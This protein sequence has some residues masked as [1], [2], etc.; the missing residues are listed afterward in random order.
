ML[1]H[2]LMNGNLRRL[3]LMPFITLYMRPPQGWPT[4][5]LIKEFY[6]NAKLIHNPSN[7]K[8]GEKT[9]AIIFDKGDEVIAGLIDFAK[10]NSLG[11]SHF[12]AIGAF[13]DVVLGY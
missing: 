3:L 8:Q 10:K 5:S 2:R 12:T 4:H 1:H 6:M 9:F 13:S 7:D 11:G